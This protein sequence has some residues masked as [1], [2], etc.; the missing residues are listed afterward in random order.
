MAYYKKNFNADGPSAEDKALDRFAEMMIERSI[1]CKVT[2]KTVVHRR[3][4]EMA[5]ESFG[6]RIQWYECPDADLSGRKERI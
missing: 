2:G 4:S 5:K 1:L 6:Q 3:K